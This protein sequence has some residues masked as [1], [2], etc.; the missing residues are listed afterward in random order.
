MHFRIAHIFVTMFNK[1]ESIHVIREN[2]TG[3]TQSSV[4]DLLTSTQN[5]ALFGAMCSFVSIRT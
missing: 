5:F 2:L 3:G 1:K 4:C